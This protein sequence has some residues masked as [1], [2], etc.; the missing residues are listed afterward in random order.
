MNAEHGNFGLEGENGIGTKT[1]MSW[2]MD[3]EINHERK[4]VSCEARW[5][6][7]G[8]LGEKA[9]QSSNCRRFQHLH[10]L[11]NQA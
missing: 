6:S 7:R 10:A 5:L 9:N 2:E 11:N 3:E 1:E 8:T 4:C